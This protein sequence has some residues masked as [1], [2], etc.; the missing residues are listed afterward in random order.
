MGGTQMSHSIRDVIDASI[1]KWPDILCSFGIPDT[2]LRNSHGPCPMC[3]GKD[4]FRFDNRGGTGSYFCS[5]CGAGY[6]LDLLTKA[7]GRGKVDLAQE[8]G[9][10]VGR[11]DAVLQTQVRDMSKKITWITNTARKVSEVP[12]VAEYLAYRGLQS[13]RLL[14]AIPAIRYYEDGKSTGEYSALVA[15][16]LSAS[17]ELLTYHITHVSGGRKAPVPSPRKILTPL[18]T[19]AGGAIRLTPIYPSIGIAEGIETALAVMRDFKIPCWAAANSGMLEKFIP[20]EGVTTVT[21]FGDNDASFTG[22][23]S[24][25]ILAH[26]LSASGIS[27]DV[28][29]PPLPGDFADRK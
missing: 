28:K 21:V 26:R 6:G 11:F 2:F 17:G 23:K 29:I 18:G 14:K 3:G 7:T 9:P 8:I 24:A 10:M 5:N 4:R 16:F 15:G 20:P 12:A 13:S 27:V 1:G 19:M 22:Q 25:Y